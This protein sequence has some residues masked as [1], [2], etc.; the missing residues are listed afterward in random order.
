VFKAKS[1][2]MKNDPLRAI[3]MIPKRMIENKEKFMQEI[4]IMRTLD[5]PNIIKLYETFEDLSN[6]YLIL[7]YRT[8]LL[9]YALGENCSSRS[10]NR[11][12]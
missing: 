6:I 1:K 11:V 4:E 9:D 7:E 5:H 10:C 12:I 8:S 3:K 2:V